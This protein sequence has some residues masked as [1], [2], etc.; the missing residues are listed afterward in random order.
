MRRDWFLPARL[1][2]RLAAGGV[3]NREVAY[4]ALANILC[5]LV[6]FYGAFTWANPPWTWLSL[7]EG[8]TV[9]AITIIGFTK[10]YDASGGD[11]NQHFVRDFSCLAFGVWLWVTVGVWSVYWTG[12]A[13]VR[14]GLI[15]MYESRRTGLGSMLAEM[16]ASYYW[17][18]TFLAAAV[19]Q[20]VYFAWLA[21]SLAKARPTAG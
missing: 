16:G 7:V 10:C 1:A 2:R 14:I 9:T 12:N 8:V 17:L 20:F 5:G 6:M 4:I 19:W 3:S 13:L 21:S 15:S 18:W 11:E